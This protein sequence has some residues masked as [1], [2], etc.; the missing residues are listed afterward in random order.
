MPTAQAIPY[1]I[2]AAP[3]GSIWFTEYAAAKVGRLSADGAITEL[4]LP[5][6]GKGPYGIT[7]DPDGIVWVAE[8][9]PGRLVRIGPNA[10]VSEV[11]LSGSHIPL[12]VATGPDGSL[13]FTE[14][15][16]AGFCVSRL[17]AD[18]TL[19]EFR[20]PTNG[21]LPDAIAAGPDGNVW[22]AER[23]VGRIARVSTGFGSFDGGSWVLPSSALRRGAGGAEFHTSV[24]VLNEDGAAVTVRAELHDQTSG[25]TFT[26]QP[27]TLGPRSQGAWD[28]A[29]A[30]LFGLTLDQG[31]F[32]PIR[33]D[34]D[35][36]IVVSAS[37]FNTKGCGGDARTGQWLAGI[38]AGQAIAIGDLLQIAV[39]PDPASGKRTNL[40][41]TNPGRETATATLRLMR[42]SATLTTTTIPGLGSNGFVQIPVDEAHFPGVGALTDTNLWLRFESTAPL[43]AFASVIDNA[44]GDPFASP[45]VPP[46]PFFGLGG[47]TVLPSSAYRRGA[48]G[49]EFHTDVR[50]LYDGAF[51]V[52]V[53]PT[54]YDQTTGETIT[55][56]QLTLHGGVAVAFDNV[57][58]TLFGRTLDQGSFGPI[59]FAGFP[60][61]AVS[62]VSNVKACGGGAT[63]GQWLPGLDTLDASR[64][65]VL[66]HLA[67]SASP[68]SG[69][70]TNVV[71]TNPENGPEADAPANVTLRIRRGDGS[72]LGSATVG[73]LAPNGFRQI[74]LDPGT[75]PAL[76]GVTDANLWLELASDHPVL[77]FASVI[78]N[79]SGDP[80]AVVATAEALP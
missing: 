41:F 38:E 61:S 15:G 60:A 66:A 80:F 57:L 3:D 26:A 43:L 17:S 74:A 46:W 16:S 19:R 18:G 45:A 73:P 35:G 39:S 20:T 9:S 54:F 56:P 65:A 52:L 24:R 7:V 44:S 62:N 10:S 27:V 5:N 72:L 29:L 70:R 48:N 63:A 58:E 2:A 42:G 40:I 64:G 68:I 30:S 11:P 53:T 21:S 47:D 34:A 75:F 31:A 33:F 37:V 59:R 76:A 28:D 69:S 22:A 49:A 50:L 77:A 79:V 51:S 78:D 55:A 67:V 25:R 71:I 12:G 4:A 1:L 14:L 6:G 8:T 36:P 23:G 13:W 32:G